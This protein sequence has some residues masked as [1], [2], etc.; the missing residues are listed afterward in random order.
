MR[1]TQTAY[2]QPL[3][4]PSPTRGTGKC[5]SGWELGGG[6]DGGGLDGGTF[7]APQPGHGEPEGGDHQQDGEGDPAQAVGVAGEV[8]DP[9]DQAGG[10]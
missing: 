4:A 9:D 1:G 2:A 6:L 7:L 5:C 8:D 10:G 3:E